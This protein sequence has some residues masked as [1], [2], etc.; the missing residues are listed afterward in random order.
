MKQADLKGAGKF[1]HPLIIEENAGETIDPNGKKVPQWRAFRE[2]FGRVT[3]LT[4]DEAII[5]HQ[6]RPTAS[7]KVE[8]LAESVNGMT[9][10]MRIIHRGK[11]LFIE[12]ISDPDDGEVFA[13]CHEAK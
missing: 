13:I 8:F 6:R 10:A 1:L 7:H 12:E 5:V 3:Y 4:G 9:E 11:V 2:P